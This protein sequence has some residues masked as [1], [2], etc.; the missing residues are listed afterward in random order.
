MGVYL[1]MPNYDWY[2][3]ASS[4]L[5]PKI[6]RLMNA[7]NVHTIS[8]GEIDLLFGLVKVA[9]ESG[10]ADDLVTINDGVVGQFIILKADT[11]DTITVKHG[12]GNI[13]CPDDTDY[14]LTASSGNILALFYDGDDSKWKPIAVS[15]GSGG[16]DISVYANR[17]S[18]AQTVN[19][20]TATFIEFNEE[21]FDT[22]TMHDNS[23]NPDRITFTTAGKYHVNLQIAFGTSTSGNRVINM[24]RYNS[25]GTIQQS[26]RIPRSTSD[27]NSTFSIQT[28]E[29]STSM[30]ATAGDY[31]RVALTQDSGGSMSVYGK[32]GTVLQTWITAHKIN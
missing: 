5:I 19:N 30:D 24:Y 23:T 18:T 11:G 6:A 13:L 10:T 32:S 22:D 12:T 14:V 2:V 9:A 20:N 16:T 3:D 29:F 15:G 8:T 25:A 17:G 7:W 21:V 26:W 31:F 4:F 28:I 27:L 1:I